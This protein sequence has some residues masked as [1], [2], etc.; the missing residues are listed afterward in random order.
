MNGVRPHIEAVLFD[1]DGTLVDSHAAV[2]RAWT[3]WAEDYGVNADDVL[4]RAHGS[5]AETTARRMLPALGHAEIKKAAARQLEFQYTDLADVVACSGA[6][7]L[8]SVLDRE[9]VPWAVVTSADRILAE[10]RLGAADIRPSVLV[11]LDDVAWGK[12]NP[13]GFLRASE[14]LRVDPRRTLVVEDSEVGLAAG[15]AAGAITAA[16]NGLDGDLRIRDLAELV[17]LFESMS[18]K[19]SGHN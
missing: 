14:L 15:R 16:L 3:Y 17:P 18:A 8:I 2:E 6:H 1:M 12:P 19:R 9:D 7:A 13:E 4:A 5:P 11:T 10:A